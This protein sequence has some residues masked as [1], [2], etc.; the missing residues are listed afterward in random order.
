MNQLQLCEP[1]AMDLALHMPR[2]PGVQVRTRQPRFHADGLMP[3]LRF[4]PTVS[5]HLS[6]DRRIRDSL[7]HHQPFVWGGFTVSLL[8]SS[9][10][11]EV[12]CQAPQGWDHPCA[13]NMG[14]PVSQA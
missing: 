13:T 9:G 4:P 5:D 14:P 7:L 2:N 12:D 10:G 8:C 3:A 6:D 11:G 1:V